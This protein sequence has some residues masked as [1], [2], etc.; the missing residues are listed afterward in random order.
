M[1]T[2]MNFPNTETK[3]KNINRVGKGVSLV[4]TACEYNC[5]PDKVCKKH[6]AHLVTETMLATIFHTFML[7]RPTQ[8]LSVR[9]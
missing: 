3:A 5:Q 6:E 8:F 7:P 4:C 1:T 2:E 9:V